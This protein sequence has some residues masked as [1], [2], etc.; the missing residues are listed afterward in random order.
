MSN[1]IS[2]PLLSTDVPMPCIVLLENDLLPWRLA[3][4][5]DHPGIRGPVQLLDPVS[6]CHTGGSL[7][8]KVWASLGRDF[9]RTLSRHGVPA[10]WD[11]GSRAFER[12]LRSRPHPPSAKYLRAYVTFQHPFATRLNVTDASGVA[13]VGTTRAE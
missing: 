12:H 13:V 9:A 5:P 1:Q 7:L 8:R 3:T 2:G 6:S 11:F 10:T 4:N